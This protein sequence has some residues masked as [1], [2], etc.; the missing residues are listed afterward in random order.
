MTAGARSVGP[1]TAVTT[2]PNTARGCATTPMPGK[3]AGAWAS[4]F[5]PG[6]EDERAT[7]PN[8]HLATRRVYMRLCDRIIFS[9]TDGTESTECINE[10][11][12]CRGLVGPRITPTETTGEMCRSSLDTVL[13]AVP[14]VISAV[15]SL[16]PREQ[17][18]SRWGWAGYYPGKEDAR[19]PSL[20][21]HLATKHIYAILLVRVK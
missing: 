18:Q 17:R 3:R 16:T 8:S 4:P 20:N 21:S 15:Q 11:D 19:A 12:N 13:L 10:G 6:K 2:Q 14:S 9:T 1:T 5:Y 7:R